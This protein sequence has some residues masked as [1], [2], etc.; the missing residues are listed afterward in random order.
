ME[1]DEE[2]MFAVTVFD[3]EL[4]A[5]FDPELEEDPPPQPIMTVKSRGRIRQK[6]PYR[7]RKRSPQK[8]QRGT[9]PSRMSSSPQTEDAGHL[10]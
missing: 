9:I 8:I 1:E 5:V 6:K 4:E 10:T 3:P 7:K 2:E